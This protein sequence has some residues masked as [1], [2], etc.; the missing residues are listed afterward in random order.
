MLSKQ[1]QSSRNGSSNHPPLSLSQLFL[2]PDPALPSSVTFPPGIHDHLSLPNS[3]VRCSIPYT[4]C[5]ILVFV[6]HSSS[7]L[8]D[9]FGLESTA[10]SGSGPRHVC[11]VTVRRFTDTLSHHCLPS[12]VL[13]LVLT[14][15]TS[16]LLDHCRHRREVTIS[17]PVFTATLGGRR[18]FPFLTLPQ[19][20]LLGCSSQAGSPALVLPP[21]FPLIVSVSLSLICGCNSCSC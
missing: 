6:Q 4:P 7:S 9:L 17:S 3:G 8:H 2:S 19:T 21:R 1:T 10:M 16:T 14:M 20:L 11:H 12:A 13:T 18:P 15:F 5:H